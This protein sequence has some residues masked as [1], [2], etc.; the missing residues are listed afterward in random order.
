MTASVMRGALLLNAY[1][2]LET[3]MKYVR[4]PAHCSTLQMD[5]ATSPVTMKSASSMEEIAIGSSLLLTIAMVIAPGILLE[6][7]IA[8]STIA[9]MRDVHST[10]AIASAH[11]AASGK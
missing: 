10:S 11:Q 6:M 4:N 5:S 3:V 9:S 7:A 1:M 8:T 2:T